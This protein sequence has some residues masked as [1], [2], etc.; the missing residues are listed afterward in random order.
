MITVRVTA[1]IDEAMIRDEITLNNT[2]TC[3]QLIN[4][5]CAKQNI[6]KEHFVWKIA[7]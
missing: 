3:E 5:L 7:Q 4:E 6:E 1:F 2:S